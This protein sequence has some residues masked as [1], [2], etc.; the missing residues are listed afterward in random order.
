MHS[1]TSDLTRNKYKPCALIVEGGAMRSVFS[2]GLLDG[3]LEAQFNPFDFYIGVS[4]GSYNL[5]TYLAQSHGK[6]FAAFQTFASHKNFISY[7]RF[8]RGGHLLDLDWLFDASSAESYLDT[9][10]VFR[11]GK[12]LYVGVTEVTTGQAAYINT[13]PDTLKHAIKASAAL[14]FLYRKFPVIDGRPMTDGGVADGIPVA[15]AISLGAKRVMVVRS[16]HKNYLKKDTL[17]H[18]FI[19]WRLREFPMLSASMRDRVKKHKE[20]I[21][22]IRNPP[23][24]VSIVEVCP[25]E[26]FHIGRFSRKRTY[27]FKGYKAGKSAAETAIRHWLAAE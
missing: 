11:S 24:E 26:S 9:Q 14:P 10:A 4:A 8:I 25:P 2:S 13:N 27:L 15:K 1:D 18:R 12:P 20:V 7:S 22:L 21:A 17:A 19:R 16:R 3:F 6:S 5:A 23:P